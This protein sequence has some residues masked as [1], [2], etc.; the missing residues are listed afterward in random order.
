MR[1]HVRP[2]TGTRIEEAAFIFSSIE[3]E[4]RRVIPPQELASVLDNIGLPNSG[5]NLAFSDTITNGNGD[6]DILISLKP[7]HHSTL[8]Y[9][10]K[11]RSTLARQ[12]PAESF[13]FQAADITSE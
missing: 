4:I 1:L 5:I 11:L 8:D 2:P 6:G 12:F 9:T 7:D 3:R 13:F 10:R